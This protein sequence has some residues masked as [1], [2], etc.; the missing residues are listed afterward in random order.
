MWQ[1]AA[2]FK[3][4]YVMH[5]NESVKEEKVPVYLRLKKSDADKVKRAA[6]KLG[7]SFT[8]LCLALLE[9]SLKTKPDL[10]VE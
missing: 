4:G 8:G 6:K 5:N 3:K 7:Y 1:E 10:T 2:D 9:E